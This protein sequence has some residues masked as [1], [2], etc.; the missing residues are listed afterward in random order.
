MVWERKKFHLYPKGEA[1]K[2]MGKKK[3]SSIP[4]GRSEKGYGKEKSFI[5]TQIKK[6]K[7]A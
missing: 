6:Q 4:K 2:G 1:K 5:Y 3:V 7:R